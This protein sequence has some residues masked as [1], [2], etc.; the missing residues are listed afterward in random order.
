M[1]RGRATEIDLDF[2]AREDNGNCPCASC[3][4][5]RAAIAQ[6]LRGT[7]LLLET[8]EAAVVVD[9]SK[10]EPVTHEEMLRDIAE[11][12]PAEARRMA[13]ELFKVKD[14]PEDA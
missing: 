9:P 3:R 10:G 11:E 7:G 8:D 14:E 13:A 2:F 1:N 4:A 12:D 5:A 6:G